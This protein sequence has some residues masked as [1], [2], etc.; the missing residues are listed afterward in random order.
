[1]RITSTLRTVASV[2]VTAVWILALGF[3]MIGIKSA[4]DGIITDF[5]GNPVQ[6]ITPRT[7]WECLV[8]IVILSAL[9]TWVF[10]DRFSPQQA[11]GSKAPLTGA[12]LTLVAGMLLSI[13]IGQPETELGQRTNNI[14]LQ[15][16]AEGALSVA[17]ATVLGI[18][19]SWLVATAKREAPH[20]STGT[21]ATAS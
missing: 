10:R 5:L 4:R 6:A 13:I 9:V 2:A 1:M 12:T 17:T 21:G 14:V 15:W 20:K 3:L 11:N 18:L 16:L 19:I 8:A 7:A